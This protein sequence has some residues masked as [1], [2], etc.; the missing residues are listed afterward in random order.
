M[1][2][3]FDSEKVI[4][5]ITVW[6]GQSA[7]LEA[8]DVASGKSFIGRNVVDL[9]SLSELIEVVNRF[10]GDM[11]SHIR[12]SDMDETLVNE[13]VEKYKK[14]LSSKIIKR[15][16][17]IIDEVFNYFAFEYDKKNLTIYGSIEKDV[18]YKWENGF[19]GWSII[20][21]L[22]KDSIDPSEIDKD[23]TGVPDSDVLHVEVF[24]NQLKINSIIYS[25]KFLDEVLNLKFDID[26]LDEQVIMKSIDEADVAS[27]MIAT[28]KEQVEYWQEIYG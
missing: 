4:A 9:K 1:R 18:V 7:H 25:P 19:V 16:D 3:D 23:F 10:F 21:P 20:F 11:A 14:Y 26:C 15:L 28:L 24:D 2:I 5:R 12:R 27:K 17:L 8:I 22:K 6:E 13:C